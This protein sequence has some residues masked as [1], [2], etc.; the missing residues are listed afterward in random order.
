MREIG[1]IGI[2]YRTAPLEVR[3]R[4]SFGPEELKGALKELVHL[5]RVKEA[6]I[7][8]TCN[9]V[10]VYS[11]L[12][13]PQ[14]GRDDV[15]AFLSRSRGVPREALVPFLYAKFAGEAVGHLFRVASSLD[16]MVVG[17][18]QILGQ[19]KDAYTLATEVEAV[20]FLLHRLFQRAFFVAK[21]VRT[22]TGIG[23]RAISV[24]FVAVELAKKI[25][26]EL[27]GKAVLVIGAG[28]MCELAAKHLRSA[29][30]ERIKVANRTWQR[31]VE[32][33]EKVGGEPIP[34]ED[35]KAVLPKV[36]IVLSST[37]ASEYI[38]RKGDVAWALRERRG[39]PI[40][41]IDIAVPRDV[42]PEVNDLT[43]AY[44]YDIDDLQEVAELNVRDRLKEAE[45]AEAI[46]KEEV[47]KFCRWYN[48]LE[49]VPT[50]VALRDWAE[51]I[52]RTELEK[53]LR[54]LELSPQD[55]GKVEALTEA[56]VNKL[57]HRPIS[58]LKESSARGE[59]EPY[60]DLVRRLFGLQGQ[61]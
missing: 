19:I 39:R 7:L 12:E 8:S 35:L 41:F 42:D 16:S 21:R 52:R 61:C 11:V 9:R 58:F 25:F 23:D 4:F 43:D 22:E 26:G 50:I 40:F 49:A 51:G 6:V 48:T 36:D 53:F 34:F 28:Q 2:S 47:E 59:V 3:E 14:G 27:Q 37:G 56:I 55:R 32:L 44:L 24:S 60:V 13:D 20:D 46:V 30:V 31:A 29:G 57:L 5:P 38:I 10:E 15:E 54:S 1:L 45:R 18:P 17:E 33:A